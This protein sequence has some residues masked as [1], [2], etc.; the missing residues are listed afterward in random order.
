MAVYVDEAKHSY[1]RMIMCH[2]LADT[3]DELFAM[4][5]KIG[6][7]RKWFQRKASCP[8]FDIAKSKRAL[9]IAAGAVEVDL[10]DLHRIMQRIKRGKTPWRIV[11][12]EGWSGTKTTESATPCP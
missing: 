11:P 8:H 9:A 3:Q 1:G 10:Y 2:M 4:A 7:D 6:I 12:G 5:D